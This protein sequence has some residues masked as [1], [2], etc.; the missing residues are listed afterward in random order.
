VRWGALCAVVLALGYRQQPVFFGNQ[1]TYLLHALKDQL[2]GLRHD[3]LANTRDPQPV[4]SA[5]MGWTYRCFGPAGLYTWMGGLIA[6]YAGSLW[7]ICRQVWRPRGAVGLAAGFALLIALQVSLEWSVQAPFNGFA[8][9]YLLGQSLQPSVFGVSLLFAIAAALARRPL[10]TALGLVIAPTVHPTYAAHAVWLALLI[11]AEWVWSTR[12]PRPASEVLLG[13][14][15]GLAPIAL[16][17]WANFGGAPPAVAEQA[18]CILAKQRIAHHTQIRSWLTR[19]VLLAATIWTGVGGLLLRQAIGKYLIGLALAGIG[20]SVWLAYHPSC[21]ASLLFPQRASVIALPIVCA[22]LATRLG[23][24]LDRSQRI[25]VQRALAACCIGILAWSLY[26]GV[27]GWRALFA[28]RRHDALLD[29]VRG[30]DPGATILMLPAGLREDVRLE[31]GRC[32]VVDYKSHPF[33]AAEIL[34]WSERRATVD[35]LDQRPSAADLERAQARYGA[36]H[37]LAPARWKSPVEGRLVFRDEH[38]QL[39]ALPSTAPH[40]KQA[41]AR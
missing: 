14:A 28:A 4:F 9:Q 24:A 10:W 19:E 25:W 32:L 2:G 29:A 15:L 16:Y 6:V 22:L 23:V 18:A 35:A 41:I 20:G 39:I 8:N 7:S 38:Q 13:T 27:A 1:H 12:S 17:V 11:A 36:T 30:I 34:E 37:V 31:T 21:A 5:L 3:W 33:A 40:D 26:T